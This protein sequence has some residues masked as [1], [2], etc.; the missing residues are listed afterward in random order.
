MS[1]YE[2]EKK[3][4]KGLPSWKVTT[5]K[6]N[7]VKYSTVKQLKTKTIQTKYCIKNERE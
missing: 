7:K 2:F 3:F 5:K 1:N 6:K 4:N